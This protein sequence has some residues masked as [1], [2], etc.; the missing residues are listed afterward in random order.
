[1]QEKKKVNLKDDFYGYINQ[2]WLE[3]AEVPAD[4]P[5]W[6]AFYELNEAV[7]DTLRK[8]SREWVEGK[9]EIPDVFMLEEY[10]KFYKM[11]MDYKTRNKL[12]AKPAKPY[13]DRILNIKTMEEL[14]EL[15]PELI[16]AGYTM[17]VEFG[18]S[19]NFKN[20]RE[21][22]FVLAHP[23]LILPE[24]GYY[25]PERNPEQLLQVYE[26]LTYEL[27]RKFGYTEAKSKKLARQT[28]EFD[29]LLVDYSISAVEQ[30]DYTKRHN[31]RTIKQVQKRIRHLDVEHI[32]KS[33]IGEVPK[34]INVYYLPF[35]EGINKIVL[36]KN[37][38]MLKA[39]MAVKA[40]YS[41]TGLLSDEIRIQGG[42]FGRMLSGIQEPQS[43][44]KAAYNLANRYYGQVVGLYYG[45]EYFGPE[46]KKDVSKMVETMI[47]VYQERL[48]NN[49]WLTPSTRRKA[50]K[51][52][53]SLEYHV[54]YP[55]KLPPFIE[56]L[57]VIEDNLVENH[58]RFVKAMTEYHFSQW[59][60]PVDTDLW[61]MPA[62]MVNAYY[63]PFFNHI[64]FPAAILQKPYYSL[65]QSSAANYGG[66]GAV[67]AHEISHAFDNNGS[68]FDEKGN[69]K[70]WWTEEDRKQYQVFQN[71]MI[72]QFDG[73]ET[74]YGP[75]NGT[76]TVS[77]NL[78]DN[79]GIQCA[80]AAAQKEKDFKAE[81][82][83]ENWARVWRNVAQPQYAQMLLQVDVHAP[84]MLRGNYPLKNIDLF[85]ETYD[86]KEGDGMYMPKEKRIT[87]W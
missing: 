3:T 71:Q 76:L 15:Y 79:G 23:S 66:I 50:L 65:D 68:A 67:M 1:M 57:E 59:G 51:K 22:E 83:F 75:C 56:K 70:N 52:L 24:K 18:L 9:K 17:P 12:K 13:I 80:L 31:P 40:M 11:A 27:L 37:F 48:A 77:E 10:V 30:A 4:K 69:M 60:K 32:V 82:F 49:T 5:A 28:I 26:Q 55:E 35:L 46:A 29:A 73:A 14:N 7:D 86:I 84:A 72:E 54:G 34:K 43:Q 39:W 21:Y 25:A 38:N 85:H 81:D 53:G 20:S 74:P 8:D 47:G 64:V 78:A 19:L 36:K 16:K 2:E 42:A 33:L 87:V 63:H 6:S 61:G 62:S 58:V 45:L 41:F 44:E